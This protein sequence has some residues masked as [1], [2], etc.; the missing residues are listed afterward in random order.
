MVNP[1]IGIVMGSVSMFD[2]EVESLGQN[3]GTVL[4]RLDQVSARVLCYMDKCFSMYA[5]SDTIHFKFYQRDNDQGTVYVVTHAYYHSPV[6]I[7]VFLNE[8]HSTMQ[9]IVDP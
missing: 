4:D 5:K 3:E 6:M 9:Y 1:D 7:N 2:G 8:K